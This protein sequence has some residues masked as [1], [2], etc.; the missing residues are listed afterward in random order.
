MIFDVFVLVIVFICVAMMWNEGMWGNAISFVNAIF[1]A[2]I[3][4]NY[5]EPLADLLE[6]QLPSYTYLW[7]FLSLWLLFAIVFGLSRAF[8]DIISN[9]RVKFKLPIEQGG[10]AFFAAA[11]GWVMICFTAMTLHTAPIPQ[12]AFESRPPLPNDRWLT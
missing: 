9:H 12:V 3:A 11:T 7:D 10:R 2:A 6:K 1:A 8:T 4:V 5:F